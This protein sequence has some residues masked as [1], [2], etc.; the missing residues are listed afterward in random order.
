MSIVGVS[1]CCRDSGASAD[2]L[3]E[4]LA[5]G[6]LQIYKKGGKEVLSA[7]LFKL[8]NASATSDVMAIDPFPVA[9][10]GEWKSPENTVVVFK[11]SDGSY[12][13]ENEIGGLCNDQ[14]ANQ[15]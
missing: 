15:C 13:I 2:T 10:L 14:E 6:A 11:F 12:R 9:E 1:V 5:S 4:W 8:P 3:R 7:P